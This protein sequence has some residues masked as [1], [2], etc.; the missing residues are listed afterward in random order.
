M[1][2]GLAPGTR[3]RV[4]RGSPTPAEALAILLALDQAAPE[5]PAGPA[6]PNWR[7]AARLEGLNITR[8]VAAADLES[9]RRR[10][11]G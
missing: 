10:P 4:L 6:A 2:S 7:W 3:L 11:M 5:P 8:V 1:S 9:A